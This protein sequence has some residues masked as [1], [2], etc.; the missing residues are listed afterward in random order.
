[1]LFHSWYLLCFIRHI[2]VKMRKACLYLRKSRIM[3][4]ARW[5]SRQRGPALS[6]KKPNL[7]LQKSTWGKGRS[8]SHGLFS[9]LHTCTATNIYLHT[10][11]NAYLHTYTHTQRHTQAHTQA[12][13]YTHTHTQTQT[14][15]HRSTNR[16]M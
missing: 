12:H 4:P 13:R 5:L 9:D 14:D 2:P 11:T 6:P 7:G 3:R 10:A 15:I 8:N 1:M 16:L